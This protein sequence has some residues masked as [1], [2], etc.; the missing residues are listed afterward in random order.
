[1]L[2][3][4]PSLLSPDL[5]H[6]LRAM[7]H[8]DEI[9]IADANFPGRGD[10]SGKASHNV[11]AFCFDSVG[12]SDF[13]IFLNDQLAAKKLASHCPGV[14]ENG[15]AGAIRCGINRPADG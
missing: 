5:L 6:A 12:K 8:G 13:A 7:G 4:I 14:S 3:S 1:M 2:R 9:I 10:I 15:I 11:G